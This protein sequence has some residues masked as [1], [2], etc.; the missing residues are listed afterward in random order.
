MI[1]IIAIDPGASGSIAW[2]APGEGIQAVVMPREESEVIAV[3]QSILELRLPFKECSTCLG[4]GDYQS[5]KGAAVV[6]CPTCKGTGANSAPCPKKVV[7]Y[8]E[9]VTGYIKPLDKAEEDREN[10]QPAHTM[11]KFGRG[12]GVLVGALRMAGI[13]IHEVSPRTWQKPYYVNLAKEGGQRKSRSERK[14]ILRDIAQ[15]QFMGLEVTLKTADALL[16]HAYGSAQQSQEIEVLETPNVPPA[17]FVDLK[18]KI[19][20]VVGCHGDVHDRDCSCE[21]PG[22]GSE[23]IGRWN[24]IDC[25]FRKE[26]TGNVLLHTADSHDLATLP[27]GSA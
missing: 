7:A 2:N 14:R 12:V 11:F 8:I 10:R 1:T 20:K 24:G 17:I 13:E 21:V 3:L 6:K 4:S 27:K 25:V 19:Q 23:F 16:I 15:R 26:K 18:S 5:Y 9:L 22:A